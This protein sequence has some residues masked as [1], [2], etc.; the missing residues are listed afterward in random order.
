MH[1]ACDARQACGLG[2]LTQGASDTRSM[3]SLAQTAALTRAH[4]LAQ[5]SD[6]AVPCLCM[7]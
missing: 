1:Y 5:D 4:A 3:W 2:Q 6:R 7:R